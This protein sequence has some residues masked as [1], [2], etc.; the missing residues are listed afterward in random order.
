MDKEKISDILS[1]VRNSLNS[2]TV[3]GKENCGKLYACIDLLEQ[4]ILSICEED[5]PEGGA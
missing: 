2:V 1:K 3:S 4:A 5:N